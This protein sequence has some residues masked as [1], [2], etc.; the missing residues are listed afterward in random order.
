M[1]RTPLTRLTISKNLAEMLLLC[2]DS[3][4]FRKGDCRCAEHVQRHVGFKSMVH[5]GTHMLIFYFSMYAFA[6]EISHFSLSTMIF[7]GIK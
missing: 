3:V 2:I 4:S 1:P 6:G 5:L 7:L